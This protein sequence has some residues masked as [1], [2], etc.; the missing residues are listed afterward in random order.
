MCRQRLV[1]SY[2]GT[3]REVTPLDIGTM[4]Y[5][6]DG[7]PHWPVTVTDD[8]RFMVIVTTN[9]AILSLFRPDSDY[10]VQAAVDATYKV[11]HQ[12]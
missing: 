12:F 1:E 4:P 3:G 10:G 5:V 6:I 9:E 8:G 11:R 2:A 7:A